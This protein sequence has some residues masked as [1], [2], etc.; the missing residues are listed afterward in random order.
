MKRGF[1]CLL[2][3]ASTVTELSA[4]AREVAFRTL[5]IQ[6][7]DGIDKVSMAGKEPGQSVGV[8]LFT[9][10]SPEIK[11]VFASGT[12]EFYTG[13]PSAG[14]TGRKV[15][16]RGTLG[17]SERQLFVFLPTGQKGEG[18]LP[19]NLTCYDDDVKSFPM[20]HVRAINLAPVPVRFVIS[21]HETP[22]IPPSKFAQFPHSKEVN[23]YNMYQVVIQFLSANGQWVKG[24]SV[25]WKATDRRREIVVTS[26]DPKFNQPAVKLYNDIPPWLAAPKEGTP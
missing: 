10:V 13:D 15:V 22:Q 5:C 6:Q 26:V 7:A 4:Q 9:D 1:L 12:V 3:L 17:K 14:P 25:S 16:A 24:Q 19:Y 18:K 8:E 2:A 21:G 20:G 11:G 23:D